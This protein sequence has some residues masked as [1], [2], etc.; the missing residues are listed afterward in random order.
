[1]APMLDDGAPF[2]VVV[3]SPEMLIL[4]AREYFG[5]LTTI[6]VVPFS[7]RY[8]HLRGQS[9]Q[10]S[11]GV[12][13]YLYSLPQWLAVVDLLQYWGESHLR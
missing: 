12:D 4:V 13:M 3:G 11:Q 5:T 7:P 2:A 1:M 9:W 6:R 10:P 8:I